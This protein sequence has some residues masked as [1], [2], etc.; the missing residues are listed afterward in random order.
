MESICAIGYLLWTKTKTDHLLWTF[1]TRD[2]Y[3]LVTLFEEFSADTLIRDC[4]KDLVAK[5]GAVAKNAALGK[6]R[7]DARGKRIISDYHRVHKPA[8]EEKI[9]LLA[10]RCVFVCSLFWSRVDDRLTTR[11]LG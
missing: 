5:R 2:T 8:E 4:L 7:D 11:Y 1:C 10:Q 9:V 3:D 6:S